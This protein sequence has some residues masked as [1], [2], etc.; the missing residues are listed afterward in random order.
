MLCTTVEE[1]IQLYYVPTKSRVGDHKL[2][3]IEFL[4]CSAEQCCG[5]YCLGG[6]GPIDDVILLVVAA[7]ATTSAFWSEESLAVHTY[8]CV[9]VD[10]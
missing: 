8:M 9:L 10:K 2:W 3:I 5:Q 1:G 4:D 7:M 6:R